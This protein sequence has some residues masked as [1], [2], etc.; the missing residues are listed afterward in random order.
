MEEIDSILD[1]EDHENSLENKITWNQ[2]NNT[3]QLKDITLETDGK[4]R[5]HDISFSHTGNGMIGIVGASGA[6]KSTFIHILAGFLH[7]TKGTISINGEKLDSLHRDD[8]L[9]KIAISHNIHIFFH[10]H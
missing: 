10:Y 3:I 4:T 6:G 9:E 5:L 8:W 2:T 7:P 1:A